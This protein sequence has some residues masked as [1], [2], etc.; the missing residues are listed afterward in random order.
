MTTD[1]QPAKMQFLEV[2]NWWL[3]LQL[4]KGDYGVMQTG[5]DP[6]LEKPEALSEH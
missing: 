2:S 5:R 1:H 3:S 6:G 4:G